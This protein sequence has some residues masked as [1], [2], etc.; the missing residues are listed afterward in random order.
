MYKCKDCGKEYKTKPDYCECGNNIFEETGIVLPKKTL[1]LEQKSEILSRIFFAI[2]LII[3]IIIWLIPTSKTEKHHT[4]PT[5]QVTKSIPNIDTIWNSTPAYTQ[6][7]VELELLSPNEKI[8][9]T[10]EIKQSKKSENIQ[11]LEQSKKKIIK[12]VEKK[13]IEQK[14]PKQIKSP[15][16]IEQKQ[17]K[18][19]QPPKPIEEKQEQS[20]YNPNSPM[21]LRYKGQLRSALF[22]KFAVGSIQGSGSCSIS[23]S[24]NPN[25]KLINRKFTRESNNKSLDDAVYYMLMSLPNFTPPPDEYNGEPINMNFTINNGNYEVTI[26]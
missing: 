8:Q 4:K 20:Y 1:T 14:P 11:N 10:Q 17:S 6:K 26:H 9:P 23:F 19:I 24:I 16:I 7:N 22:S 25:G 2:C 3:S 5:P 13:A 15:K 21:M 18:Q 12:P